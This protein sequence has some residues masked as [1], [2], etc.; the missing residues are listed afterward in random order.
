MV[1]IFTRSELE[2]EEGSAVGG[3]SKRKRG[4][5]AAAGGEAEREGTLAAKRARLAK[6]RGEVDEA[7]RSLERERTVL[8]ELWTTMRAL[9]NPRVADLLDGRAA[10][11]PGKDSGGA[12]SVVGPCPADGC[13]GYLLGDGTCGTCGGRACVDCVAPLPAD[14][15]APPHACDPEARA[16]VRAIREDSRPCPGCRAYIFRISGCDQMWCTACNT[17]FHWGSGER[18]VG[19]VIHNPHAFE[20]FRAN[21]IRNDG[22]GAAG[23]CPGAGSV[24]DAIRRAREIGL[25][26]NLLV[27]LTEMAR[28]ANHV[29][30]VTL[31]RLR[32]VRL[33]NLD[34]RVKFLLGRLDE[35]QL[36]SRLAS[37]DRNARALRAVIDYY[38]LV[39]AAV[40]PLLSEFSAGRLTPD[41]V[42]AAVARF[43][44]FANGIAESIGRR[45]G[46]AV[47][48]PPVRADSTSFKFTSNRIDAVGARWPVSR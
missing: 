47:E 26:G 45:Y 18:I 20:Y 11:A 29:E 30:G 10:D 22:G 13:R 48:P 42:D 28:F 2:G 27:K 32:A 8:R 24:R 12:P 23:A 19:G 14:G 38:E 9:E 34:L 3:P 44:E 33:S 15:D 46:T 25:D 31:P 17:A 5:A 4:G 6:A 21:G 37:R 39:P 1:A 16:S 41:A 43:A 35:K 40:R 36:A 7:K